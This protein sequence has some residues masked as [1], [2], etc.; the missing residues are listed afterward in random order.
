MSEAAP[1]LLFGAIFVWALSR[2]IAR[3]ITAAKGSSSV[4]MSQVED[5]EDEIEELRERVEVLEKIITD[6]K[7]QLDRE[8]GGLAS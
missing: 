3:V 5:L 7:Y 1:I 6:Q 4:K 2:A 8:I